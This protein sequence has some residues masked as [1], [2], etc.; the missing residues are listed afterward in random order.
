MSARPVYE[1]VGGGRYAIGELQ[2][3]VRAR[4]PQELAER[5]AAF[6]NQKQLTK[7]AALR[8]VIELGLD[9]AK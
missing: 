1:K 4:I 6:A 5:L 9:A 7:S 3:S 8:I 2:D